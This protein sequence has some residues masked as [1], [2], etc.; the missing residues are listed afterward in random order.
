MKIVKS[1]EEI[2]DIDDKCNKS[3]MMYCDSN[4][5]INIIL[6][7]NVNEELVE[8]ELL[9]FNNNNDN[10]SIFLKSENEEVYKGNIEK[11]EDFEDVINKLKEMEYINVLIINE[12]DG[13]YPISIAKCRE[14]DENEIIKYV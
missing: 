14:I 6:K 9:F 7:D 13:C 1:F 4:N 12:D 10:V 5:K 3:I 8:P 11:G 2:D